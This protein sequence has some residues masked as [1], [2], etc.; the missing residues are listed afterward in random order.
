M[1]R[2]ATE[3]ERASDA[4]TAKLSESRWVAGAR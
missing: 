1:A 2:I 4:S 3:R